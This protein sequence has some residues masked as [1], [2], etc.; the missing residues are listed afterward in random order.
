LYQEQIDRLSTGGPSPQTEARELIYREIP[1][2]YDD[3]LMQTR[4]MR[5]YLDR[6]QVLGVAPSDDELRRIAY[7]EFPFLN[8]PVPVPVPTPNAP[9][10]PT[11]TT[12]PVP[13]QAPPGPAPTPSPTPGPTPTPT[14]TG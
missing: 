10:V 6:C 11:G 14:P 5:D 9:P 7:E 2:P 8:Q 13:T 1:A 4:A 3:R 12:T